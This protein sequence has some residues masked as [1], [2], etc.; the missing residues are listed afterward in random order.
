MVEGDLTSTATTSWGPLV[1]GTQ[2]VWDKEA[3]GAFC[4]SCANPAAPPAVSDGC[5][6]VEV[7]AP[8]TTTADA[9]SAAADDRS[10][11]VAG[12][13]SQAEFDRRHRR[14]EQSLNA[15]WGRLAG[16]ARL[17][18]DDPQSTKAWARGAEGE[19]RL[20]VHLTRA[21]GDRAVFLHDRKVG[22]ANIDHVIVASSG[23]WVVDAKNYTGRVEYRNVCGWLG[24]ADNRIF[25]GGR[26]RTKLATGLGWQITAVRQAL[27][28][29][30]APVHPAL[31]FTSSEWGLF[32][33]PFRHEGVLVTWASKLA[34]IV[35]AAGDLG[36]EQIEHVA[37]RLGERLRPAV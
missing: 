18:S 12:A 15:R 33:K 27:G 35:A 16:I 8:R 7:S 5:R 13:S 4:L 37:T 14:R 25:V 20:A 31:C 32:A 30:D 26:D 11:S 1:P 3:G 19:R 2:A 28:D 24:P 6:D 9:A 34:E 23:V 22:R 36:P 17:L 29:L 21:L 10:T